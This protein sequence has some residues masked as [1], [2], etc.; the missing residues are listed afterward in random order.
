M[1]TAVVRLLEPTD[2][3]ALHALHDRV[4]DDSV[5]LR[6]FAFSRS[7]GH[8]YVEHLIA[9]PDAIAIVAE[10]HGRIVALATAEPIDHESSEISF[11]VDDDLRGHGLGTMLFAHLAAMARDRGIQR[12]EAEVLRENHRM[13]D[14]FGH[15][16]FQI[17]QGFETGVHVLLNLPRQLHP[18]R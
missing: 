18:V 1:T 17:D 6:F 7:A 3:D 16:G 10:V 4:S 2:R 15:A 14:L 5:R 8:Q 9:S 13:L 12:F 11:L